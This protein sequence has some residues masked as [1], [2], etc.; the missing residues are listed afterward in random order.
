MAT[1]GM[2][3]PCTRIASREARRRNSE[4]RA[5][6]ARRPA[7]A[8]KRDD[9]GAWEA[10]FERDASPPRAGLETGSSEHGE[11]GPPAAAGLD[12][13]HRV[14]QL[15]RAADAR[16]AT[17]IA[18]ERSPS[19]PSPVRSRRGGDSRDQF[20]AVAQGREALDVGG[21]AQTTALSRLTTRPSTRATIRAE[22]RGAAR[23]SPSS[24]LA[25]VRPRER[26]KSPSRP[27]R[28]PRRV[29]KE[30]RIVKVVQVGMT[31]GRAGTA[32]SDRSAIRRR[33]CH[34]VEKRNDRNAERR[35]RRSC[36]AM[37]VT[38]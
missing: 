21:S 10:P 20:D 19:C 25:A 14:D 18:D 38:A 22:E 24:A 6:E 1:T 9:A 33:G 12:L 32:S 36:G 27:A 37:S 35:S 4:S 29:R 23:S 15:D 13:G 17:D 2:P 16:D 34:A 26:R 5:A 3:A 28:E 7:R 11:T 30:V 31:D 8:E